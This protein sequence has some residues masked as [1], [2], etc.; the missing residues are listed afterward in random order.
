MRLIHSLDSLAAL[1]R[2]CVATV[3]AFDA[4]HIGHQQVI[5]E[6]KA[7]AEAHR[8][9]AVVVMFEP[10]PSEFFAD[11]DTPPKRIYTLRRRIELVRDSKIDYLVC[12]SFTGALANR[13]ADEFI[14][15]I[16][17]D[18]LQARHLVV[19][20]DFRFG[21]N[22]EGDYNMLFDYGSRFGFG[23]GRVD[24]VTVGGVRVSSTRIRELL[25][26]GEFKQANR[27]LGNPYRITERVRQGDKLGSQLGYPTA[28]LVFGKR[29]PPLQGVFA[30]SVQVQGLEMKGICNAGVRPTV[31]SEQYRI[32]T[33]VFDFSEDLYG[34]RLTICPLHDIRAEQR[35]TNVEQLKEAIHKDVENARAFFSKQA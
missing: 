6:T 1:N 13:S 18:G 7:V 19:G 28:N 12:L 26:N 30:V 9:P 3:G 16:V 23:V 33:H 14:Q 35:Y 31:G 11:K 21:K 27:L 4:L 32:E 29:Q 24:A 17:M 15:S 34:E 8:L 25:L 22:R 5:R 2:P 20:D 10:L